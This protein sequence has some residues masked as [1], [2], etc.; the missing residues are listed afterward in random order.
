MQDFKVGD[1]VLYILDGDV[2]IITDVD[3]ANGGGYRPEPY[4]IE[5]FIHPEQSGWH[6]PLSADDEMEVMLRCDRPLK[7]KKDV[8]SR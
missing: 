5:W 3:H 2:G 6:S 7:E 1:Y 8:H 4:Y